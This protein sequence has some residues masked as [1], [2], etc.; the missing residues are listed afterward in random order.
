MCIIIEVVYMPMQYKFD[1][2]AALK[3]KGYTSNKIRNEKIMSESTM[4]KFRTGEM[5]STDNIARLCKLLD[6]QP[7]DILEY[8][9]DENE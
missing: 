6:C 9:P 5:V 1:I 8:V 3:E 7:G 2:I 4:Q